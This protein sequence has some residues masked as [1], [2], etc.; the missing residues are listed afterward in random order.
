MHHITIMT[1][2]LVAFALSLRVSTLPALSV[3]PDLI[4]W[5]LYGVRFFPQAVFLFRISRII[6]L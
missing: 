6:L 4:H 2:F 5:E 1:V 3:V